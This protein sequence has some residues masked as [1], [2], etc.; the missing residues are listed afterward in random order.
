MTFDLEE[1][2]SSFNGRHGHSVSCL[3]ITGQ[4]F[5]AG[6]NSNFSLTSQYCSKCM[7]QVTMMNIQVIKWLLFLFCFVRLMMQ[8]LNLPG[9]KNSCFK[10]FFHQKNVLFYSIPF[11]IYISFCTVQYYVLLC[12]LHSMFYYLFYSNLFFLSEVF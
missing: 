4:S 3:A 1:A 11:C 8:M 7:A 6:H 12:F 9:L 10:V 2:L 5:K